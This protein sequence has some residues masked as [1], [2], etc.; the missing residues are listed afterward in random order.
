MEFSIQIISNHLQSREAPIRVAPNTAADGKGASPTLSTK[1]RLGLQI[2][3]ECHFS[4]RVNVEPKHVRTED[5]QP[6]HQ[7]FRRVSMTP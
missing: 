6:S 2:W 7:F 1:K 3:C 4:R 5:E